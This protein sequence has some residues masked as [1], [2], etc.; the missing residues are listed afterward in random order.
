MRRSSACRT[1]RGARSAWPSSSRA[2]GVSP[3]AEQMSAHLEGRL[4]RYKLPREFLFIEALPRTA[5]GKVQKPLLQ[6][7]Y[8]SR[9]VADT[10]QDSTGAKA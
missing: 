9:N 10:T 8:A 5:Y 1:T 3:T 4:A 6:Q 2:G 7:A